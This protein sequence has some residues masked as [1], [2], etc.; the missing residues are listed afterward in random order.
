LLSIAAISTN[1][2]ESVR[3][4]SLTYAGRQQRRPIP[5]SSFQKQFRGRGR[6]RD[7]MPGKTTAVLSHEIPDVG[8]IIP[9]K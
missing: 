2:G 4:E 7:L 3:L 1:T 6:L 5:F 8:Q 9:I